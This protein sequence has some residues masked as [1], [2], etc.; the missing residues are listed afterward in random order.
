MGRLLKGAT[1]E[2]ANEASY[3]RSTRL[4]KIGGGL[5]VDAEGSHFRRR[6]GR[7]WKQGE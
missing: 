5:D 1:G 3:S 6:F 2:R 4:G 7:Q